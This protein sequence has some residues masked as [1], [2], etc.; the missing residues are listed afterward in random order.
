MG[1][2][3]MMSVPYALYAESANINY[4]SISNILSN[5]ST[6]ITNV[7]GGMGGG[8]DFL[9]PEKNN[10]TP[11]I[12]DFSTGDYTI[13]NGK[14]LYVPTA[15]GWSGTIDG[16]S[17]G[18]SA[19]YFTPCVF[20]EGQIL[21]D[22]DQ[23]GWFNGFLV[24]SYNIT[25]VVH[26]FLNGN[27]VVPAGKN[28]Y[29]LKSI[30]WA[31][32]VDGQTTGLT[33][34]GN[35]IGVHSSGTTLS[36]D[37]QS[38]AL[39]GYL[40]D[41]NYFAGCGGGGSSSSTS[42]N[43][44]SLANIISMDSSFLASINGNC[45]TFGEPIES[46][47]QWISYND[48]SSYGFGVRTVMS[49]F[50][51]DGILVINFGSLDYSLNDNQGL[52]GLYYGADTNNM[53][54]TFVGVI[55]GS[56][57]KIDALTIPVKKDDYY[58]LVTPLILE[59]KI[60]FFPF[61]CGNSYSSSAIIDYDSL[62]N[63]IS[64]DSTFIT[65]IGGGIGGGG[66]DILFPDGFENMQAVTIDLLLLGTYTVPNGRTL[67][68]THAYSDNATTALTVDG[69]EVFSFWGGYIRDSGP[70]FLVKSNSTISS[71]HQSSTHEVISGYLVDSKVEPIT[72]DLFS[73]ST[74]TV[75]IGKTLYIN[76]VNSNGGSDYL[77]FDGKYVSKMEKAYIAEGTNV[78][79]LAKSGTTISAFSNI[80]TSNN[81]SGYLA[82]E[83]Y[84]ANCGGGSSASSG[85]DSTAVANMIAAALPPPAA[86]IG[87]FRDGGVVFWVDVSGQHG[88]VCD[89][90]DLGTA[91]W[92]CT[93]STIGVYGTGI[94]TGQ[95][96]TIDI[97]NGCATASIA[98]ELCANSTAQGYSD[99]FLPSKD[100]L[101]EL[102][103][104]AY[105][106]NFT[107]VMNG[108]SG[109]VDDPGDSYWSSSEVDHNAAFDHIFSNGTPAYS[110]KNNTFYVRAVRAF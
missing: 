35:M 16:Q 72:I 67:Y 58:F 50:N 27:Y 21:G 13:P 99:W 18:F 40:A 104:N 80:N 53:H 76:M 64:V 6:F 38:G 69:L 101:Q 108:G 59:A 77:M 49:Q 52:C 70:P 89:L 60:I 95:Q 91:E 44:D 85:L 43:Y 71:D 10:V 63:I 74:Y 105:A 32:I 11:I 3:Q 20:S 26:N 78:P 2:N 57:Q 100:A 92:G 54:S 36:D 66:C 25:P 7:G 30:G 33:I 82:D 61:E 45:N 14:N 96:N 90:Q 88:L 34:S 28:F 110:W 87:D 93:G 12:H 9:Y 86:Q 17:L 106:I 68:I 24:D 8:C 4:D 97:L 94:G 62:A 42:V 103:N 37:N 15:S 83:N 46:Q 19:S 84:F 73:I 29:L 23:T 102:Y 51:T 109:F 98:A 5:D 75:P 107:L 79:L 41:E 55:A 56:E 1:T 65:N 81:I 47:A 31:S 48:T 39:N 22:D